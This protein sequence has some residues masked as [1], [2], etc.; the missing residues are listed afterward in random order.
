MNNIQRT[1]DIEVCAV[2][3]LP[4]LSESASVF[5]ILTACFFEGM[6]AN[7]DINARENLFHLSK[8]G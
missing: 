4:S 7:F 1:R 5:L 6:M 3:S 2:F 8:T